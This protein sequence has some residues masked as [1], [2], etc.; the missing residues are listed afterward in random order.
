MDGTL[1]LYGSL[2]WRAFDRATADPRAQQEALLLRLLRANADTAFGRDFGFARI[3]SVAD[4]RRQVP[5][6]DYEA[7]RPY[8]ARID[9]GE[10]HVLTRARLHCFLLTSG[11]TGAPKLVPLTRAAEREG[12]RL[13]ALWLYRARHDHPRLLAG[14]TLVVV[15]RAVAG[16]TPGG[17]PYGSASGQLYRSAAWLLRRQC[18]ALGPA[19]RIPDYEARYYTLLRL[20]IAADVSFL[21]T[22]NPSTVLRLVDVGDRYAADLIRDVHDGTLAPWLAISAA[23]RA[24]LE[25]P[26]RPDPARARQLERCVRQAGR[27]RPRE[28]WPSLQ[29]LGCW[30]GGSVGIHLERLRPWLPEGAATRDLGYLASE[31]QFSLPLDDGGASGVLAL[32][33]A[34]YEFLPLDEEGELAGAPLLADE[35][36]AGADYRV[37]LTT[38]SGLYR[39]DINDVV[40]VTGWHRQTPLIEFVRKGADMASITGEKLHVDQVIAAMRRA[41]EAARLPLPQYCLQADA[42]N[43]RYELLLELPP[44]LPDAASVARLAAALDACLAELNLEYRAKRASGRLHAPVALVMRPGW[45]ERRAREQAARRGSQA[46]AKPRLLSPQRDACAAADVLFTADPGAHRRPLRP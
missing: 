19:P 8:V 14:K 7:F 29:L 43:S 2:L 27:L 39:Y 42:E 45:A 38:H 40:R 12:A 1:R 25:A 28:C 33:S 30:K 31:G 20:G 46:Q 9:R 32:G 10:R 36:S 41:A 35:L 11:T 23:L 37:L 5:V 34:F 24:E 44:P 18:V 15:D 3:R 26:L 4:Y 22:P 21:A 17:V 16:R 6:A 13:A